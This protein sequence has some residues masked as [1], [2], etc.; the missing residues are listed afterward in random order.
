[1]NKLLWDFAMLAYQPKQDMKRCVKNQF[2]AGE[3]LLLAYAHVTS[4]TVPRKS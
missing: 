3:T 1:M 4:S 2:I